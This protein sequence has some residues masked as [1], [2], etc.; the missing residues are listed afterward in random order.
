MK[1]TLNDVF[2]A[3][4]ASDPERLAPLER[5]A[6]GGAAGAVAQARAAGCQP[7]QLAGCSPLTEGILAHYLTTAAL[8]TR[9]G[10]GL[11]SAKL[12]LCCS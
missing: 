11:Q 5:M 9:S 8:Q 10:N 3:A 4:I 12:C 2:K 7:G 6:A 1:L